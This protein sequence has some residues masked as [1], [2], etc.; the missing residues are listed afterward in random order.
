MAASA[1]AA[2]AASASSAPGAEAET[3]AGLARKL[4][5]LTQSSKSVDD[6][7]AGLGGPSDT[8][9]LRARIEDH[10]RKAVALQAEL[11]GGLRRLRVS[12]LGGAD[13]TAQRQLKRLEEQYAEARERAARA[14]S[15][16]RIR[17][18][19]FVPVAPPPAAGGAAGGRAGAGG[20]ASSSSSSS[21]AAAAG[22]QQ[23]QLEMLQGLSEVDAAIME[24]RSQEAMA[25]ARASSALQKTQQD[26]S[27]LV[28]E[29]GETVA[30]V[31][32]GVEKAVE[33]IV[34]GTRVLVEAQ[35]YQSN[36]R[37]KCACAALLVA[38]L[39]AAIAV[40][41]AL[42]YTPGSAILP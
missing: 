21:S 35:A 6:L 7:S 42:H 27:A 18:R 24:E 33:G 30:Q 40:P 41:L 9:A 2:A 3:L 10:E 14:L 36:V 39:A 15:D 34:A 28:T 17:R 32:A 1:S 5:E 37:W 26:L 22:P 4:W 25:I 23:V 20:G 8:T 19:Q 38:V 13:H 16:S 29:Q 31:E 12:L 11:D